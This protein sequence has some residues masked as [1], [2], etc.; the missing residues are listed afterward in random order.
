M[1]WTDEHK[2]Y[3]LNHYD[4]GNGLQDCVTATGKTMYAVKQ[5]AVRLG[6]A[7]VR[8]NFTKEEIDYIT[9]NYSSMGPKAVAKELSVNWQSVFT[10]V[11]K[12]LH[13]KCDPIVKSENA[14]RTNKL[15][16]RTAETRKKLA[17]A[18]RKYTED[19]HCIDCGK[20]IVRKAVRCQQCNLKTRRGENHNFWKGGVSD[21]YRVIQHRLW[22]SW[23]IE[24]LKRDDFKCQ[25]CGEHQHLEVHH[26]RKFVLIREGVLRE[27]PEL[28]PIEDKYV[29]A[30][31]IVA[32]HRLED[33]ITLCYN[34]HKARHFEKQDELL[35]SPNVEDEGNQ[36]PSRLNVIDF[37]SR[38]VQRLT[39]EDTQ[40]NNPDTSVLHTASQAV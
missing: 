8:R 39:G 5:M 13:L 9:K 12:R 11:Q 33:G 21:L 36:Q 16:V 35:E 20:K 31:L 14:K 24:V 23:K 4:K 37:V 29:L 6:V 34:C 38:K 2:Q 30:D 40:T 27:H 19:N 15:W 28:S 10:L 7:G 18:K 3:L 25:D 22:K 26:T 32:E 17:D 1:K